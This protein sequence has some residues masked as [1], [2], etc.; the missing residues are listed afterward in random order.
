MTDVGSDISWPP[1]LA[2]GGGTV[3]AA[4]CVLTDTLLGPDCPRAAG[5]RFCFGWVITCSLPGSGLVAL[6]D[7]LYGGFGL[8]L[9]V[10]SAK[11]VR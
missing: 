3:A 7:A 1:L 5:A 8:D 9:L 4:V 2:G 6:T 10:I 11:W